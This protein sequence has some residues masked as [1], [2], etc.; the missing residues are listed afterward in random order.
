M[1]QKDFLQQVIN[2]LDELTAKVDGLEKEL[3]ALKGDVPEA[4][5]ISETIDLSLDNVAEP[6]VASEAETEPVAIDI[7]IPE[8]IP[9]AIAEPEA[10]EPVA[11]VEPEAE[12]EEAV[13][14]VEEPVV[15]V[16]EPMVEEDEVE[17][18][19]FEPEV[20]EIPVEPEPEPEPTPEPEPVAD[21]E[22]VEPEPELAPEPVA[23]PIPEEDEIGDMPE[24]LFGEIIEPKPENR[25]RRKQKVR[26]IIDNETSD[27]AVIDVM[28]EKTSWLHDIP[29]PEV[30]SLRSAIGLGDQVVLIRRLFRSDSALYQT[31]IEK[32][33]SMETL[34]EAVDFL[35]DTFP[36]WDPESEDVYKFMMAVRRKIRK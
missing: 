26:A 36:D 9:E 14:V 21:P 8:F 10:E 30:K 25:G 23:D 22:P 27:K 5:S 20:E 28:A 7:D 6:I 19:V 1:D 15:E 16:E 34:R 29:G 18:P 3:R 13:E 17:E 33:N 4:E 32:L 31:T 12:V 2:R 24:N 35:G 11:V